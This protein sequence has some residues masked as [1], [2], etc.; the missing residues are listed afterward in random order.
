[1]PLSDILIV[2]VYRVF[3]ICL[4]LFVF[5]LI[6]YLHS[7]LECRESRALFYLSPLYSQ[8][9]EKSLVYCRHLINFCPINVPASAQGLPAF[10][11]TL[12]T[13]LVLLGVEPYWLAII[14]FFGAIAIV[15]VVAIAAATGNNEGG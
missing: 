10:K 7:L 11:N 4:F 2:L 12:S 9:I 14:D 15:V 6:Y 8:Y 5:L 3:F 13:F 1:M